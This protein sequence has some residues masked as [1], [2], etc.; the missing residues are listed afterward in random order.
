MAWRTLLAIR[1]LNAQERRRWEQESPSACPICGETLL[2]G[3]ENTASSATGN[4]L[5]CNAG[6]YQWPRDGKFF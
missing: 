2:S 4:T 5:Y 1:D 6:H 3:G